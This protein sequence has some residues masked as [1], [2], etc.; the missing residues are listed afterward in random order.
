MTTWCATAQ[1]GWTRPP[2]LSLVSTPMPGS[3]PGPLPVGPPLGKLPPEVRGREG[4]IGELRRALRPYP[5]RASRAFVIAGMGGLGKYTIALTAARMA[6]ERG[7]RVWW[8]RAADTAQLT[9]GMLEVLRELGA[10]ESVTVPV[11]EGART[12]A[13]RAWEFLNGEH[14]AGR[15]WL[16]VF[17]GADNP[18]VL[19]GAGAGTPADGTGWLRPD[20]AGMVIV[21]TRIRDPRVWGPGVTLRELRPLD[22][23]A[24]A[25]V[26]RDLAPEVAD[27]G[28]QEARELSRRLG[29]LPLALH[30]AGTYLGSPF[31]RWSTFAEY[32]RALDGV[33]LPVALTDIEER[34]ADIHATVQRT[35]DLSLDALA[36][37]GM[38][39]AR[40]LLLVLSCFAPATP[41]PAWLLPQLPP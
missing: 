19:A 34:G 25:E 4:L 14:A 37:E 26:L 23:E 38:P 20:P 10:P 31:A 5:W 28:G 6:K 16:L 24:G 18:V 32:H 41:I 40:P 1:A 30:L 12:A 15:R 8:V 9:S 3:A 7:Y 39:Q 33:E 13:A 27:H 36:A 2:G 22:D 11:R 35:W 21:T 29:G 17:E